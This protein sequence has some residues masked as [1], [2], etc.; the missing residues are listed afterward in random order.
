MNVLLFGATGMV[1]RGTLLECVRDGRV[2]SVLSVGRSSI[3]RADSKV[4]EIIQPDLFDLEP[5]REQFAQCDACFFCL[6]VSSAGMKEAD[7]HR[8]TYELTLA[9]AKAIAAVNTRLTFCYVSGEGTDSTERGRT[10]WAR[11]K[12]KTENALMRMP[13]KAVY[14]F[15]PGYIQPLDGIRSKT[16]LYQ[17]LYTVVRPLYPLLK[18]ALPKHVTTTRALGRA[19]I[20]VGLAGAPN[21]ILESVEINE[22]ARRSA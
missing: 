3:G 8:A 22:L 14:M 6:G 11:V 10:M 7:Y 4:R 20:E 15:R 16:R 19:M 18:V 9:A 12:G 1:G 21:P 5:V 17:S 2:R 13:F